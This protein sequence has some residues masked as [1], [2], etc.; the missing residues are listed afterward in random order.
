MDEVYLVPSYKSAPR[1]RRRG[2][3][4]ARP[5]PCLLDGSLQGP[6]RFAVGLIQSGHRGFVLLPPT[7]GSGVTAH[8]TDAHLAETSAPL[9]P[10]VLRTGAARVFGPRHT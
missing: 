9:G 4:E 2:W 6:P 1:G 8:S 3:P 7:A 5:R 10:P